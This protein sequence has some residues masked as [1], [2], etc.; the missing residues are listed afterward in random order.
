MGSSCP[1]IGLLLAFIHFQLTLFA[2]HL[3]LVHFQPLLSADKPICEIKN[4]QLIRIV[5]LFA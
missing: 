4:F 2:F 1:C 3:T 5:G